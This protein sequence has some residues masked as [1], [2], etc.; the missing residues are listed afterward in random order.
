MRQ[1]AK[2][3]K[4]V[5]SCPEGQDRDDGTRQ[6]GAPQKVILHP[7]KQQEMLQRQPNCSQVTVVGN[8]M[9]QDSARDVESGYA[10]I[11]QVEDAGIVTIKDGTEAGDPD[12]QG[13]MPQ[14]RTLV[15]TQRLGRD[16]IWHTA[17]IA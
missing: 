16:T 8:R 11:V 2:P 17:G 14:R 3:K 7:R 13:E 1:K 4:A 5:T 6:S 12:G 15:R 9:V 10:V